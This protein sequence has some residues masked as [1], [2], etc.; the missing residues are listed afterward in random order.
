MFKTIKNNLINTIVITSF[1]L[2]ACNA[3]SPQD[4]F[5][6]TAVAQTVAAQN[7]ESQVAATEIPISAE[8]QATQTPL[9]F[10]PTLTPIAPIA[11]PTQPAVTSNSECAKASLVSETIPDGTIYKPGEVFTKTWQITNTSPCV[12]NT[13]YKIVFWSGDILGG[14]YVYNLPQVTGPGA[15]LPISLVLTA[16]KTDG[17]YKSEWMLQTPDNI[18]FGVGNYSSPFYTQ[19]VVSS[20]ATPEYG[21]T[22]VSYN[23]VRTPA[24]GCPST[25]I[26]Y[27]VY[28][29]FTT[30][31]PVEFS[32]IWIQS[33]GNSQG[34]KGTIKM[35]TA[36]TKTVSREWNLRLGNSPNDKRW[37]AVVV[38]SPV[39]VEY[40]QAAFSF[41]CQ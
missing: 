29:T 25:K 15:T 16:P 3:E 33:D 10:S 7:A 38:T 5:I 30:N 21:V 20:A 35:T 27:T 18:N 41:D 19:I 37:M 23:V 36:G 34:G 13:G 32:Y 8:T 12:W 14:A 2:T 11:S 31:G 17:P 40:P 26:T 22:S 28:A 6:S 4:P 24:T 1:L 9:Q 39:Y